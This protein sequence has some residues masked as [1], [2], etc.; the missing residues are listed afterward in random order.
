MI[1]SQVPRLFDIEV[2]RDEI[3]GYEAVSFSG[4]NPAVGSSFEDLWDAGGSFNFPTSGETWEVLS[5]DVNDTSAGTGARQVL[6]TGLDDSYNSQTELVTMNGTTPVVTTRT[7]WFRINGVTVTSSGSN[8][9]NVGNIT[10]R[11]SGG[12][13][14]RSLMRPDR[15]ITFNGFFTVPAEK[16]LFVRRSQ[17]FIPK[18]EDVIIRN[19]IRVFGTNTFITGGDV[20]VYQNSAESIF[21]SLPVFPEKTDIISTGKSTNNAVDVILLIEGILANGTEFTSNLRGI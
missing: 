18:N 2:A 5:D 1:T 20:S 11:V 13:L 16:T 4:N 17:V 9:V 14:T 10:L 19:K 3:S 21:L 8:Q 15:G 12:G 7:D 6:I